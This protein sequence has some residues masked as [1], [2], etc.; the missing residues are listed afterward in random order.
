MNIAG[1]G[2]MPA[3]PAAAPRDEPLAVALGGEIWAALTPA[4]DAAERLGTAWSALAA[5]AAEPNV[6]AE[7]WFAAPG[8]RNLAPLDL[9]MLEVWTSDT[10]RPVLV[11]LLPLR[12]ARLYGRVPVRHVQN[13]LHFHSFLG[14]PLIRAGHEQA[15]WTAALQRLDSERWASG[16]LHVQGL[17]E[18]GPA[19]RGLVL[20]ARALG[21]PCD[22][23]HR[24]E[25]ALLASGLSPKEYYERTVR[26]KKRKELKRLSARLSEL[27]RV[28]FRTLERA[29]DLPDWC[30]AFL[31]LERSGWKGKA[32]SALGCAPPTEAFF[33]EAL[34]GAFAFGRLDFLRLDLDGRAI[35]MLVNLLGPPGS[36]SFKIAY[37]EDYSRFSP[38][39]LIQI[40]NLRILDRAG[41]AWMDSCAVE[42]HPMI[43]SLWGERRGIVRVTVPLAGFR[44][45]A[46]FH[47]CRF[48]EDASAAL[49]ARRGKTGDDEADDDE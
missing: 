29:D 18:D 39:V 23:V 30:D 10:A 13:W 26:K 4:A 22:T 36:F 3:E 42:D 20:A 2:L 9:Q 38:G 1:P 47:L 46:I 6:F 43:N 16:F 31:A 19:H 48:L 28:E 25:R 33:R 14:S 44:R 5:E 21:R 45:R 8:L 24:T 12:L 32:G 35:A 34:A 27:G 15:F 17:S 11:G 49:R 37:D 7:H 41:I 40:E